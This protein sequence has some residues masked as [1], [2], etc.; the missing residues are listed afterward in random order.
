MRL[1]LR[2]QRIGSGGAR[3]VKASVSTR[4]PTA[5]AGCRRRVGERGAAQENGAP[6]G[7]PSPSALLRRTLV[8]VALFALHFD[9]EHFHRRRSA[10]GGPVAEP[11]GEGD[12][13]TLFQRRLDLL[14]GLDG[15]RKRHS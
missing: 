9:G 12:R 5:A 6:E 4:F 11:P 13:P 10:E 7:A 8:V 1:I 3:R 2:G 14:G 15:E